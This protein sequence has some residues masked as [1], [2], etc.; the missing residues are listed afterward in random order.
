MMI[1]PLHVRS[2]FSPVRGT[3]PLERLVAAAAE[4]GHDH[5]ALTDVNNI[6]ATPRFW[7]LANEAGLRPIIGA[8]IR[9]EGAQDQ[10]PCSLKQR[11]SGGNCLD[12]SQHDRRGMVAE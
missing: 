4:M 12:G 8:E 3:E 2:G 9:A 7:R 1:T 5:L 10:L 6:C 11:F